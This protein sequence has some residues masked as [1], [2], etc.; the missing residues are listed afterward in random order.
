V[1]PRAIESGKIHA[2][3]ELATIG[4]QKN[5]S[6]RGEVG[7]IQLNG[8]IAR[9]CRIPL[10]KAFTLVDRDST[11]EEGLVLECPESQANFMTE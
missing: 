2:A 11:W 6:L 7:P 4:H 3:V 8:N 5:G 1:R 9:T 10:P